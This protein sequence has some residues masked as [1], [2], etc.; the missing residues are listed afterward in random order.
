MVSVEGTLRA[1]RGVYLRT[2]STADSYKYYGPSDGSGQIDLCRVVADP[3]P[4]SV[5][6]NPSQ[7]TVSSSPA[8]HKPDDDGIKPCDTTATTTVSVKGTMRIL[9]GAYIRTGSVPEE[10]TYYGPSDF[11][12]QILCSDMVDPVQSPQAHPRSRPVQL[13]ITQEKLPTLPPPA[14][15][16]PRRN[17]EE[18][19]AVGDGPINYMKVVPSL[20]LPPTLTVKME[21]QNTN[22]TLQVTGRVT[23]AEAEKAEPRDF[24]DRIAAAGVSTPVLTAIVTAILGALFALIFQKRKHEQE[25]DSRKEAKR[26]EQEAKQ[27]EEDRNKRE[28]A[29]KEEPSAVL[30]AYETIEVALDAA[31]DLISIVS[32]AHRPH[33]PG[34]AESPSDLYKSFMSGNKQWREKRTVIGALMTL[35]YPESPEVSAA[36]KALD[37]AV[38]TYIDKAFSIYKASEEAR[39]P[40]SDRLETAIQPS[41]AEVIEK[42]DGLFRIIA[43]TRTRMVKPP[44]TANAENR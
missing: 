41:R 23:V 6:M 4:P 34:S 29:L 20:Q 28:A 12:G 7:D 44:T 39:A 19:A 5:T 43:S 35:H 21:T 22:P 24:W 8:V 38:Q 3:A 1:L 18:R 40:M 13:V 27:N 2:G 9:R 42:R 11:N 14:P 31:D 16:P 26:D 33:Q 25:L 32:G 30:W 36:W 17:A 10:F 37:S 15:W